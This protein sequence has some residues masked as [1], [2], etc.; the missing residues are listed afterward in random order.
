[1]PISKWTLWSHNYLKTNTI[2]LQEHNRF[3]IVALLWRTY[4]EFSENNDNAIY[5]YSTLLCTCL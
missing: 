3:G 1:M 5:M 4:L 2:H